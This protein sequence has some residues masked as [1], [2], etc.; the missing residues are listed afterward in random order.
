[1]KQIYLKFSMLLL[2]LVVGL[3][4]WAEEEVAYTLTP[5][6]GTNNSYTGNCD[7][8]VSDIT[9][10]VS[11]NAQQ[12][13]WRLGGKSITGVDRAIYSKTAIADNI[14]S[15]VVTNGTASSI[16]VNSFTLTVA[17]DAS[18][19][20]VISTVTG[21]FAA[22]GTTTFTRPEGADWTGRYYKFTYNVTV[23]GSNNK[24]VQFSGAVFNKE[25][26]G[27]ET[28]TVA[29]PT[30]SYTNKVSDGVIYPN[31]EVS[32]A[33]TTDD[34]TIK[35]RVDIS[36]GGIALE[37]LER[38]YSA[39]FTVSA[40]RNYITAWAEKDGV[41]SEEAT[42]TL[43]K[44]TSYTLDEL[45]A[46]D[47]TSGTTVVVSFEN[48]PIK[49]IF[50]TTQGYRN[51]IYF[52]IQK[53]DKDIEIFYQNVPAE[54][55]VGGTVSGTMICPW[56]KYNGTWEL[57]PEKDSWSWDKLTYTAPENPVT[58]ESI[59]VSGTPSQTEYTEGDAFKTAGLVVTGTYSDNST[60]T[61]TS[62]ISWTVT[63]STLAA[64]TTSVNVVAKVNGISS[65]EYTVNVTVKADAVNVTFDLTKDET[66]TATDSK[67]EWVDV[68]VTMTAD[69]ASSTTVTNNYYPGANDSYGNPYT[70]T[71]FYKS[72]TLTFTP[73]SGITL[74]TIEYTA[75]SETYATALASSTWTNATAAVDENNAK[76]VIITPTDGTKPV[77]A[78]IGAATGAKSVKV[79]YT[80]TAKAAI[81][82]I[83]LSG[84]YPT[85]F[86]QGDAFSSKNL[87]VTAT[88]TDGT[89]KDVTSSASISGYDM[90]KT[91]V[92][93]VT[94]SY[95]EDGNTK[96]A[97][98][99]INVEKA[100]SQY[101]SVSP[102]ETVD[103]CDIY[104]SVQ[105]SETVA[106]Y[107]G[108][109]FSMTFAKPQSSTT[110]TKYYANGDAV[111]AYKDNTIK[112]TAADPIKYVYVNY[113]G[114]YID[115]G[116]KVE[117]LNTK[118]AT[119]TFS[120]NCRFTSISVCYKTTDLA[121][122]SVG[123]ATYYDS[124]NGYIMPEGCEGYVAYY[125]SNDWCFEKAYDAGD[126]VPAGEALVIKGNAG[127][128]GFYTIETS[129][130]VNQSNWL[131]GTDTQKAIEME[132]TDSYYFYAL[133]LNADK[134]PNSVGFY[135]MNED[136]SAF[137]NGA[138]KAYLC[139]LKSRFTSSAKM[140]GFAFNEVATAINGISTSATGTPAYNLQG[141]RVTPNAKGFVIMN[142]KKYF[143]K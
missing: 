85:G 78:T 140:T 131:E 18:F 94:V 77:V 106:D 86:T 55:V 47:I 17:S 136:G 97:T 81:N 87:V 83:E 31:S 132:A 72:S 70:S 6:A 3:S 79:Y 143:N 38:T 120:K 103:F 71:R 63:P 37:G 123:Y 130:A 80:G 16:T 133:T 61:I 95:T 15:I 100:A 115:S 44:A 25:K 54:W 69:K 27:G 127:N 5:A 118:T 65:E 114:S 23:S 90:T 117:G 129:K 4:S 1:M 57:A 128:H 102:T 125:N 40:Q 124:Q 36:N 122:S 59:A 33:C 8:K 28:T 107:D 75:T 119:I 35:Y 62:G 105:N 66:S 43:T 22:S 41:K 91:G 14:T 21:T 96:T 13:P 126:A 99:T 49:S 111:R 50:T 51:G 9:W 84:E 56:T 30:I 137:T 113:V 46:A 121:I 73:A 108:T 134:D 42:L 93:T 98:Y 53:D 104:S 101:T 67:L 139:I 20:D 48:L 19:S 34:A 89:T 12:V 52:D 109:S 116:A 141:V 39:P 29:K 7:V 82:K 135:W 68:N 112:I 11:G 10:N 64:G 138:H 60:A 2:C 76:L 142:G 74:G 24:F 110:P 88:Y 26:T 58:L 32:L 92:Q 45:V